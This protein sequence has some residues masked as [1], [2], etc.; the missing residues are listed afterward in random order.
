MTED[1]NKASDYEASLN[2]KLCTAEIF[3][4]KPNLLGSQFKPKLSIYK[5]VKF[6]IMQ[7]ILHTVRCLSHDIFYFRFTIYNTNSVTTT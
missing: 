5:F 7:V 3:I 1:M 2:N 4:L 6:V